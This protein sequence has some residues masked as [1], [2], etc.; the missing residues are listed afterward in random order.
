MVYF[1]VTHP[2]LEDISWKFSSAREDKRIAEEMQGLDDA[3]K[4]L[5]SGDVEDFVPDLK[6]YCGAEEIYKAANNRR[7]EGNKLELLPKQV[8]WRQ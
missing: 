5:K 7:E 6:R 2:A 1:L 4:S 8:K 3:L